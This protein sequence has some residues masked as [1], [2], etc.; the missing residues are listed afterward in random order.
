M[1][2]EADATKSD[3]TLHPMGDVRN[4]RAERLGYHILP[5]RGDGAQFVA[6]WFR[7]GPVVVF[8]LWGLTSHII[9]L[10]PGLKC[11]AIERAH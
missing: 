2:I 5:Q 11:R 9:F 10:C 1:Q 8:G 6:D 3:R 7:V 4:A